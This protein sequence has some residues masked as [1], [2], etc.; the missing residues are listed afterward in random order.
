MDWL[1]ENIL[2]R[3]EKNRKKST[4]SLII[5]CISEDERIV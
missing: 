1:R 5:M 3:I 2:L 4:I